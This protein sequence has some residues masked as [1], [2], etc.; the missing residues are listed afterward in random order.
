[1]VGTL[2]VGSLVNGNAVGTIEGF[3]VAGVLEAIT[4]CIVGKG[5][6]VGFVE[7]NTEGRRI[8]A[9]DE[10]IEVEYCKGRVCVVGVKVATAGSGASVGDEVVLFE[11]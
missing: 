6:A 8:G 2:E 1:M 9:F 10:G 4:V 3:I 11:K 5:S 7:N